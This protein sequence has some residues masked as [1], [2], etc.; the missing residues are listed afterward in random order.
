MLPPYYRCIRYILNKYITNC[1]KK[2]NIKPFKEIS[3]IGVDSTSTKEIFRLDLLI[4]ELIKAPKKHPIDPM[5]IMPNV[6]QCNSTF[7]FC[8]KQLN[9]RDAKKNPNVNKKAGLAKSLFKS[10]YSRLN[11]P[12][13][14]I[15]KQN[16]TILLSASRYYLNRSFF[17]NS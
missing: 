13:S 11:I 10:K 14:E 16:K 9:I 8:V 1:K 3:F 15:I 17:R 6:V 2:R 12:N 7:H 5:Q 4:L